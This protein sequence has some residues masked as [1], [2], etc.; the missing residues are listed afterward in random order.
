MR[1]LHTADWHLGQRLADR[2]RE[3]EH[4]LFLDWLLATLQKE[5]ID[6]LIVAGDIFDMG[7]PPNYA[8]KQY[9]DFLRQSIK[10]CDNIVVV[11]GN[12]DSIA[13]LDAPKELLKYFKIHVIGGACSNIADEVVEIKSSTNKLIGAIGAVPFLRERD[14]KAAV[15]GE[16]YKER[17]LRIK[18]GIRKHYETVMQHLLPYQKQGYPVVATGH[19][20]AAGSEQSDSEKE[21]HI[22]NRGRVEVEVFPKELDYVALG[23]IHKPQLVN[24]LDHIRYCGSPIPL[25]FS[26]RD[27]YKQVLIVDVDKNGLQNITVVPIPRRRRLIRLKGT[28]DQIQQKIVSY[29]F[30]THELTAWLEVFVQIEEYE[31]ELAERIKKLAEDKDLDILSVRTIFINQ[32]LNLDEQVATTYNLDDLKPIEVFRKKCDSDKVKTEDKEV[33]ESTFFEL[34][35]WMKEREEG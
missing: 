25:S 3:K 4:R 13:N 8:R 1:I 21:I 23:H 5:Q 19:L 11:G 32:K 17:V 28:F 2:S 22:G 12:H 30:P 20:F 18:A 34:L 7:N 10:Y 29:D 9:Y 16:V 15:A 24:G 33:L 27:D 31:P 35:D 6:V 26:E 14:I